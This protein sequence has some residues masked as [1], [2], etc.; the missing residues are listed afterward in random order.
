MHGAGSLSG[1]DAGATC[2]DTSQAVATDTAVR[3]LPSPLGGEAAN[4][5]AHAPHAALVPSSSSAA[6]TSP[7]STRVISPWNQ[8]SLSTAVCPPP[9]AEFTPSLATAAQIVPG[10]G[11]AARTSPSST[12]VISPFQTSVRHTP[13]ST[14]S[15]PVVSPSITTATQ[16]A[17]GP[18]SASRTPPSSSRVV[19]PFQTSASTAAQS[20]PGPSSAVRPPA[21]PP[22]VSP[23]QCF[24]LQQ[25]QSVRHRASEAETLGGPGL[26]PQF[27]LP[28]LP[29]PLGSF[30]REVDASGVSG[31]SGGSLRGHESG[32][33]GTASPVPIAGAGG[34]VGRQVGVAAQA[35]GEAVA[36]AEVTTA[37]ALAPAGAE[38]AAAAAAKASGPAPAALAAAT[39][40]G[41]EVAMAIAAAGSSSRAASC[42]S[43]GSAGLGA[44]STWASA[45]VPSLERVVVV[46]APEPSQHRADGVGSVNG[47]GIVEFGQGAAE[48]AAAA[49]AAAE[50][51]EVVA[52]LEREASGAYMALAVSDGSRFVGRRRQGGRVWSWR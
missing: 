36:L 32:S 50:A 49:A 37:G 19:S 4:T 40:A 12:R 3:P 48:L 7:S 27:T 35:S 52:R 6:R 18:G 8:S 20:V 44:N 26:P 23:F 24:L 17:P 31:A 45:P 41:A 13:S 43:E 9:S 25:L 33:K 29:T 15:P 16:T 42:G 10:P 21:S 30:V 14:S 51:A 1:L 34:Q 39:T 38:A 2:K 28:T 11:S 22:L 46:A 5:S 47:A